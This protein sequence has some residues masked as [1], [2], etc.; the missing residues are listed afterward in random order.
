MSETSSVTAGSGFRVTQQAFAAYL[1]NPALNP[2]PAGIEDRR[3]AIYRDL[4]FNNV[5]N[6]LR[7]FFPVLHSLYSEADW[8]DMSRGFFSQHRAETPYFLQISEEFLAWL[9]QGFVP[10]PCD[11]PWLRELAHYE[12]LELALDVAEEEFPHAGFD[13]DGD[14]LSG[15]PVHSPLAVLARYDWPVHQVSAAHRDIVPAEAFLMV[16]RDRSERVRFLELNRVSARLFALLLAPGS[17]PRSGRELALAIATEMQHPDPE[18]VVAGAGETLN[19]W[20]ERD[21]VLGTL[22]PPG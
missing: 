17:T 10:R 9:E 1:R 13:A 12:W 16:Y 15:V 18:A 3:L 14:L 6:F 2:P 19:Q 20:R 22:L 8:L 21:I 5:D 7:G 4:F 11:P